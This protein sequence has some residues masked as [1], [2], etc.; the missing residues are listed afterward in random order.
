MSSNTGG[1][2]GRREWEGEGEGEEEEKEEE[3][4]EETRRRG[5]KRK[6]EEERGKGKEKEEGEAL[7]ARSYA[8]LLGT[9]V[10]MILS[11]EPSISLHIQ[12][13]RA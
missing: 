9:I 11:Y 10:I 13:Q 2:E 1:S 12:T 6:G 8:F 5:E 3:E 7:V 4:E